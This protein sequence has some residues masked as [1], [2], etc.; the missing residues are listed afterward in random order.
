MSAVTKKLFLILLLGAGLRV[1]D[2]LTENSI[3]IDG[4]SYALMGQAFSQ[5][6]WAEALK[7]VFPP[8][9]PLLISL[10]HLLVPDLEMAARLVSMVLGLGLIWVCFHLFREL[11]DERKALW[12]A[13]F[14]AIQPYLVRYSAQALSEVTATL[15]FTTSLFLFYRGWTR[16]DRRQTTLSAILLG[17]MYLTRP[18]YI[19]YPIPLV[20]L[21]LARRRFLDAGLFALIFFVVVFPYLYYMKVDTGMWILSKKAVLMKAAVEAH[22]EASQ[23]LPK[24]SL[25]LVPSRPFLIYIRNVP[26][27]MYHFAEAMFVPFFLLMIVG[28]RRSTA[29]FRTLTIAIVAAHVLS[30]A[31]VTSSIRRF[32]VPFIPFMMVFAIEGFDWARAV[33]DKPGARMKIFRTTCIIAFLVCIW[34]G[35]TFGHKAR[36]LDKRAG[37]YILDHDPGTVIASKLPLT[38]FYGRSEWMSF[39]KELTRTADCGQLDATME[40]KGIRYVVVD[41]KTDDEH[42]LIFECMA[43][44]NYLMEFREGKD[45]LRLFKIESNQR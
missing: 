15:I 14:I 22:Q 39:D 24:E 18:E 30:I 4:V 41:D 33:F 12:G 28:F 9:Y 26:S 43:P 45:F 5:G 11:M 34:Q 38:A 29:S 17:L 7:G 21:L 37:L 3:Q 40:R 35:I 16:E 6:N 2:L 36:D 31:V 13:L 23:A 8:F 10:S 25:Y 19:V 1:V 20:V 32:S 42:R 27:V 44:R